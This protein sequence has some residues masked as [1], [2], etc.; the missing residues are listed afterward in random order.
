MSRIHIFL[1]LLRFL[2]SSHYSLFT[3]AAIFLYL[4]VL[5][6]S[7]KIEN[8]FLKKKSRRCGF[9]IIAYPLAFSKL[10]L[11]PRKSPLSISYTS[12]PKITNVLGAIS[13]T[14]ETELMKKA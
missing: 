9:W 5:V 6:I 2:F 11:N 1:L 13:G 8:N 7:S 10:N 12:D 3:R 14:I 4:R